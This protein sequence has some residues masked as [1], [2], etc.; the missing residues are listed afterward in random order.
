MCQDGFWVNGQVD[1]IKLVSFVSEDGSGL[2]AGSTRGSTQ[3]VLLSLLN[4]YYC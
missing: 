1:L 4:Y 3:F 2:G